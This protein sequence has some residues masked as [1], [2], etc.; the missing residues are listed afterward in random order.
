M[1]LILVW[2]FF[3][4]HIIL[5]GLFNAKAIL[6]EEQKWYHLTHS[7]EDKG[8]HTFSKGIFPKVDALAQLEF[9]LAYNDSAIRRF[10]H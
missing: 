5:C 6:W 4:W 8:V 10:Y 2:F 9:E 7:L 3:L 1:F